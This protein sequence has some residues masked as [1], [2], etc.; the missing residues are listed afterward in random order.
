MP[1]ARP[2]TSGNIVATI[3]AVGPRAE[4]RKRILVIWRCDAHLNS[5]YVFSL[6]NAAAADPVSVDRPGSTFAGLPRSCGRHL[7]ENTDMANGTVKWF[8]TTKG[9]GFIETE[10]GSKDVFLHIS[11]VE[12]AGIRQLADGQ[13]VTFDIESGRD[14]RQSACNLAL[15]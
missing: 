6:R 11:A 1:A 14:G 10:Q 9:F 3:P 12:R 2:R 5:A 15:A 7:Q 13:K 8:N 4:L